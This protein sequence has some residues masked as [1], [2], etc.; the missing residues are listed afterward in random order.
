MVNFSNERYARPRGPAVLKRHAGTRICH[1]GD[2]QS[3]T[4]IFFFLA[5]SSDDSSDVVSI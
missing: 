3:F 4:F 2:L 5:V 1:A